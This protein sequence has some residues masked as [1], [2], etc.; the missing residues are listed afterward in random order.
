MRRARLRCTECA[1]SIPVYEDEVGVRGSCPACGA[2]IEV[3]ASLFAPPAA[4]APQA[5]FDE[6]PDE[7]ELDT[8]EPAAPPPAAQAP[9]APSELPEGLELVEEEPQRSQPARDGA[10]EPDEWP[11]DLELNS[12][13]RTAAPSRDPSRPRPPPPSA[14]PRFRGA[15]GGRLGPPGPPWAE[16]FLGAFAYAYAAVLAGDAWKA[17]LKYA[18]IGA[19]VP[20]VLAGV[21]TVPGFHWAVPAGL[22]LLLLVTVELKHLIPVAFI[23]LPLGLLIGFGPLVVAMVAIG[24]PAG[25]LYFYMIQASAVGAR[26]IEEAQVSLSEDIMTPGVLVLLAGFGLGL[27]PLAAAGY[28]GM[29]VGGR[30]LTDLPRTV[31]L[32]EGVG[33]LLGEPAAQA[34]LLILGAGALF[35]LFCFPMVAMVLGSSQEVLRA[36]NPVNVARGI[37][38]APLEYAAVWAFCTANIVAASVCYGIAGVALAATAPPLVAAGAGFV[39]FMLIFCYGAS[40]CGW[41][42]GIFLRR[43][44]A[45]EDVVG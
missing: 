6:W 36:L 41:R 33:A 22:F 15:V 10:G 30:S 37:L 42:M 17:W 32:G 45:L 35:A 9:E 7:L 4:E 38:K 26:P 39:C 24:A 13:G 12:P 11:A 23:F 18:A 28:A 5:A 43:H 40:A 16:G 29:A 2:G 8:G 34:Q 21:S 14:A 25:A 20:L 44:P 19:V 31:M 1:S 3:P 27:I